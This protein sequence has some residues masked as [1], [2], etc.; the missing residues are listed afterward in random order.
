LITL[1]ARAGLQITTRCIASRLAH[2]SFDFF[3]GDPKGGE[4]IRIW[5]HLDLLHPTTDGQHLGHSTDALQATA[6]GPISERAEI[7][8]RDFAIGAAQ[9]DEEDLAHQR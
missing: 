1:P 4:T 9:P 7:H 2:G 6:N 3:K 8:R 5:L